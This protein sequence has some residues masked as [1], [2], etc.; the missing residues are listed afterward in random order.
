MARHQPA[1]NQT[2]GEPPPTKVKMRL[3][4]KGRWVSA[5]PAPELIPT[6]EAA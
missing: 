3:D 5:E 4:A 6:T 2:A 1:K